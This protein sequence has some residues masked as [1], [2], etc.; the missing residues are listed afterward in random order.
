MIGDRVGRRLARVVAFA[1]VLGLVGTGSAAAEAT[2][3]GNA[4]FARAGVQ[5]YPEGAVGLGCQ[6]FGF[7]AGA[8]TDLDASARPQY[9]STRPGEA[10]EVTCRMAD[11][12]KVVGF[13]GGGDA[14]VAG[15]A[16]GNGLRMRGT[17]RVPA[18]GLL[19]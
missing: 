5:V 19:D 4:A 12:A 18:C 8:A 7:C 15:C 1:A 17:G 3:V 10:V 16:S 9:L 11:L 2:P 6:T 14:V 13:F